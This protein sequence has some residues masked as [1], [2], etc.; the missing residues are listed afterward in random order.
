MMAAGR[1][2]AAMGP[3]AGTDNQTIV[4][5]RLKPLYCAMR[6]HAIADRRMFEYCATKRLPYLGRSWADPFA[7]VSS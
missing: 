7:E 2:R 6:S 3:D 4:R 5:D 1:C